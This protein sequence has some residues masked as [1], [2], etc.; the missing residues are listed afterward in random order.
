MK[1]KF[2]MGF[3]Y[4]VISLMVLMPVSA[5]IQISGATITGED[6]V[7]GFRKQNDYTNVQVTIVNDEDPEI[8]PDQVRFNPSGLEFQQC[9]QE[10]DA[11]VCTY[12]SSEINSMFQGSS[13][14]LRLHDDDGAPIDGTTTSVGFEVDKV[15]P[16]FNSAVV[17][18]NNNGDIVITSLNVI[19]YANGDGDS[20]SGIKE[21]TISIGDVVV[22]TFDRA[23]IL[24]LVPSGLSL[25]ITGMIIEDVSMSGSSLNVQ[26]DAIDMLGLQSVYTSSVNIDIGKTAGKP[27]G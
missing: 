4:F 21:V 11:V 5:T 13:F 16:T 2:M 19:D 15:P 3:V 25:S 14:G 22:R 17:E 26:F 23:E 7:E 20:G 1:S 9:T 6:N 10:V 12:T 24:G 8:T 27:K 18:Q